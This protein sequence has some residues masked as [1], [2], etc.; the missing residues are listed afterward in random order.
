[1]LRRNRWWLLMLV[2]AALIKVF[3]LYPYAVE[4]YYSQ[5]VYP[6]I[7]SFQRII[8][9]W[10][11]F[12]VGDVIYAAAVIY[13]IVQFVKLARRI[14]AKTE[15]VEYFITVSRKLITGI[16]LVY[17]SFNILWG[18]NYNRMGIDYQLSL[19]TAEYS[20]DDLLTI[21]KALVTKLNALQQGSL[22]HRNELQRKRYL[23]DKAVASYHIA[24]KDPKIGAV[25]PVNR[26]QSVKPSVYSYLGNWLGFTG[27]Y[28]PFSGEAQVNTTVP[29]F[30]RP[31]TTCHEIGH[32]L[33]YAKESEANFVGYLSAS[34]SEDTSFLYSVYFEMFAY[35]S[36]YLYYSDSLALKDLRKQLNPGVVADITE[37]KAFIREYS[38]PIEVAIDTLYAQYL[39]ANEQPSGKMSYNE[40]VAKLIAYYKKYGKV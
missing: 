29:L 10:I 9:G 25:L 40:V 18:L 36:R 16:L 4:Q 28:N 23:F 32:Q 38:S 34:V 13:L 39:M 30:V 15:G 20:T 22:A 2:L 19:H 24:V 37:L 26:F 21:N 33:G 35:S 8:F 27:Y 5:G 17:V 12:S 1:M 14:R 31:F 7:A 11:P 6:Y 3:S